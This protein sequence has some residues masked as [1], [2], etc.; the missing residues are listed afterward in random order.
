M[1]FVLDSRRRAVHLHVELR[2]LALFRLLL[3]QEQHPINITSPLEPTTNTTTAN[4]IELRAY[5]D[6]TSQTCT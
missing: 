6:Y 1:W 5:H 3:L 2:R 4:P